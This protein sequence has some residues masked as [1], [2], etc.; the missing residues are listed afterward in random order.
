MIDALELWWPFK[1]VSST[2]TVAATWGKTHL[3]LMPRQT[4]YA[5]ASSSKD[6]AKLG[7]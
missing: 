4:L 1:S 5:L 2:G 3:S 6:V 7:M